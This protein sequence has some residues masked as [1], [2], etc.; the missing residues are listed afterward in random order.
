MIELTDPYAVFDSLYITNRMQSLLGNVIRADVHLLAYLSCVLS[1]YKGNPVSSWGYQFAGTAQSTPYSP[2]IEHAIGALLEIGSFVEDNGYISVTWQ[3][4][5]QY[6]ELQW[7]GQNQRREPYLKGACS[8]ILA[9]PIDIVR[10]AINVEPELRGASN[11]ASKRLLLDDS[12]PGFTLVYEQL[13]TLSRAIGVEVSNLMVP[14]VLWLTL[15][16][17]TTE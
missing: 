1:L 15:L 16:A 4:T 8:S 9:L 5:D 14:A 3:G 17:Q 2:S 12:N 10:R 7:L 6:G 11:L 13:D